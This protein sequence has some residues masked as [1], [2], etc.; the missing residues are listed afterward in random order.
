VAQGLTPKYV[1]PASAGIKS[2]TDQALV[3]L[4]SRLRG[5]DEPR[6]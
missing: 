5:N 1:I 6:T 2:P 3:K 4:D